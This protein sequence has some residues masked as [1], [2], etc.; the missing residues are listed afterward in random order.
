MISCGK[1]FLLATIE[2][3]RQAKSKSSSRYFKAKKNKIIKI[4]EVPNYI[5]SPPSNPSLNQT[6]EILE[7][8]RREP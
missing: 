3:K 1:D 6:I 5:I 4:Q 8:N 7:T 2:K